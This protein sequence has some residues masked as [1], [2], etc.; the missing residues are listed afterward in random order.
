MADEESQAPGAEK[1]P[2]ATRRSSAVR[3]PSILSRTD[4][5]SRLDLDK[6]ETE[7]E[8]RRQ[9]Q[10]VVSPFSEARFHWDVLLLFTMLYTCIAL[11]LQFADLAGDQ[12]VS[13]APVF[14]VLDQCANLIF[15]V[16]V[17]LG[18]FTG[19]LDV[20][21]R[22]VVMNGKLVRR[23]YLRTWFVPEALASFPFD[24]VFLAGAGFDHRAHS[25]ATRSALKWLRILRL[26][27]LLRLSGI[28]SQLQIRSGL[29][30]TQNMAIHFG[31]HGIFLAHCAACLWYAIGNSR[32]GSWVGKK[33]PGGEWALTDAYV[34]AL[35]FAI[36]TM[37][38]IGYGDIVADTTSER[39][40]CSITMVIG[41]CFYAYG[42]TSVIASVS[43]VNEH[44]RRL[45]AQRDQ[46]NRYL[47]RMEVPSGLAVKL[48]EY[49]V[50]YANAADTFN[51]QAVLSFLSPGLRSDLCAL[52]NAPLL[53]RV[54]FFKDVDD[55]ATSELAQLLTP[56]LFVP[57]EVVIAVGTVGCE[58]YI[59]KNGL[60]K[61][62]IKCSNNGGVN[63]HASSE[64]Q[65]AEM[66]LVARLSSNDF[67]GE[68]AL[69][70]GK[71]AKRNAT[72]VAVS[73]SLVYS[74][75]VDA[76]HSI[77]PR[78]PLVGLHI[79]QIA[80]RRE[81]ESAKVSARPAARPAPPSQNGWGATA[82]TAA[83]QPLPPHLM[84]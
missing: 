68:G 64:G 30:Y 49:F 29:K 52:A 40:F 27:R 71:S 79:Q 33:D 16:D 34:A 67:F 2:E 74:L 60:L 17:I 26:L 81:R 62:L 25:A 73:Y 6:L 21:A 45:L 10:N 8:A 56:H 36:T 18:F 47:S 5:I 69:L 51:E 44:E 28:L 53:R 4:T 19:Y 76:M 66:R 32:D 63:H 39:L 46:L 15:L 59:I 42:I 43:G 77:L 37:S 72:V 31:L 84:A 82:P 50:H 38:T 35:Y 7:Q 24:L 57:D 80:E 11:P 1:A 22:A 12:T 83:R 58:V 14:L 78:Y 61:V 20:K 65:A 3:R 48:R 54:P 75:H 70:K 23:R 55:A 41:S 9:T 13:G